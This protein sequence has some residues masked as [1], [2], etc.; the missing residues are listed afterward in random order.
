MCE[1]QFQRNSTTQLRLISR[2]EGFADTRLQW[3]PDRGE[4]IPF[5]YTLRLERAV[6]IGGTVVDPDGQPVAGATVE[7]N[8]EENSADERHPESHAFGWI[9][10]ESGSDGRWQINRIAEEMIR[11]IFGRA[12]HPDY[13]RT[14]PVFVA[15]DTRAE[16][17]LRGGDYVFQ[18]GRATTVTGVVVDQI[19]APIANAQVSMW[20]GSR[21]ERRTTTTDAEGAFSLEGTHPSEAWVTA[22]ASGFAPVT[23]VVNLAEQTE[24]LRLVLRPGRTLRFRVVDRSGQ[25]LANAWFQ[26]DTFR[27]LGAPSEVAQPLVE[28]RGLADAEGRAVW[29]KAP[30]QELPFYIGKSGYLGRDDVRM[31]PSEQ[32]YVV[33]LQPALTIAGTVSDATTTK[34]ISNFRILCGWPATLWDQELLQ[35]SSLGHHQLRFDGGTFRHAFDK[36][37]IGGIPNPGYVFKFEAEGY[38]PYV[39]RVFRPDEGEVEFAVTLKPAETVTVTVVLPNGQPAASC[40]VGFVSPGTTLTLRPGGLDRRF[41]ATGLT[42]DTSG[43]FRLPAD[44]AVT[45]IVATHPQGFAMTARAALEA[46]P[47]LRL[48]AWA[49]V[50]GRIWSAGKPATGREFTLSWPKDEIPPTVR[51]DHE[52]YRVVSDGRGEFKFDKVPPVELRL[53][54]LLP[55]ETQPPERSKSWSLRPLE[56][57]Q[58]QPGQTASVEVGKDARGV[59]LR[60]RWP[61]DSTPQPDE[62]VGFASITTPWPRPPAEIRG[63]PQAVADWFRR[64]D[65]RAARP[66]VSR[67]FPL[68]QTPD[69]AWEAVDVIPGQYVVR[70]RLVA[71]TGDAADES[72]SRLFEGPVVVP[73]GGESEMVDLGEIPVQPA[74]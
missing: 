69:G 74:P 24:P 70:S 62:R 67:A 31:R 54:E 46:E 28:F 68:K 47:V 44:E 39:T 55:Y 40:D 12:Q 22:E 53:V 35:W 45:M 52:G 13:L 17:Q 58:L 41:D 64:P 61:E 36:A 3:R 10:V 26:F 66:A 49:R 20:I 38:A 51:F 25:P 42:T 5:E 27:D 56:T 37:I 72:S 33:V 71:A 34:L 4:Q 2:S 19:G 11:R 18:L 65:V 32:E 43:Q 9:E 59:R 14:P 63:N 7:F 23:L 1:V 29:E 48:Q 60:L 15:Q 50:E 8:D 73:A 6:S 16:Q 30:D 57:I 21:S